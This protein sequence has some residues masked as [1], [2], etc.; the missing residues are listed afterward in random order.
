MT[1][2]NALL[3]LVVLP[4]LAALGCSE[5]GVTRTCLPGSV[6]CGSGCVDLDSDQLH[7]GA[8]GNAC[9]A[10]EACSAGTCSLTC[11]NG[12]TNCGGTCRDLQS[13]PNNCG[14]C[15]NRVAFCVQGISACVSAAGLHWCYNPTACGEPCDAVCSALGLG[16]AVPDTIWFGAQDSIPECQAISQAF[17]LGTTVQFNAWSYGCLEDTPGE[18][19]TAGGLIGPIY[20]SSSA[21]CP[22][23]H[24][25]N[26][27]QNGIACGPGSRRS[28]CPCL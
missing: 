6:D 7:C 14:A 17:G 22:A 1:K 26:M 5:P 18:H 11:Q 15:G 21:T 12:L 2:N 27:D 9:D 23:S 13:D 25:T 3:A 16:L 20:C 28:I 19:T 8:C 4:L 10:G 24:R